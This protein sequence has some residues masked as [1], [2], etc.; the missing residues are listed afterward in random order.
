[1]PGDDII[2]F[3]SRG[4]GVAV[5]RKSCPNLKNV[6]NFR[7]IDAE[8]AKSTPREFSAS[9]QVIADNNTGLLADITRLLA[10]LQLSIESI[11]ARV[12]KNEDA[13][14]NLSVNVDKLGQIDN[15]IKRLK[16]LN[17]VEKVYRTTN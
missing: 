5:H 14:I 15:L 13:I 11:N 3:I 12:G 6:E 7:L 9:L 1:M 16:Q 4:R 8:W 2:G 10:D 17:G